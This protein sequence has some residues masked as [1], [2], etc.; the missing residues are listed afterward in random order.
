MHDDM[1]D[2]DSNDGAELPLEPPSKSARK[3]AMH[4]LQTLGERLVKLSNR[5]LGHI[6][7]DADLSEAIAEARRLK[8]SEALRRQLRYIGK[9]LER[10]DPEPIQAA[11]T[12]LDEGRQ[13][14]AKRFHQLE[15]WRDELLQRGLEAVEDVMARYPDAD[16]QQLRSLLLTARRESEHRKPPAAARKLFRYLRELDQAQ[17]GQQDGGNG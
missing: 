7:L 12:A 10:G 9:L 2:G 11:L 14:E 15:H 5:Q 4:A 13:E 17:A 8:S 6:P 16:R 3:R 1:N